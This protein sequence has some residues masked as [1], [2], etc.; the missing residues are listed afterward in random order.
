[1][2]YYL[3]K[4][5]STPEYYIESLI[6]KLSNILLDNP[7]SISII[8]IKDAEKLWHKSQGFKISNHVY[9]LSEHEFIKLYR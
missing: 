7:E 9:Y 4:Y 1:M 5:K 6:E 2:L 8:Y 3:Y